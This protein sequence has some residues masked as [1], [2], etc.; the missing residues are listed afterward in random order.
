[1][2]QMKGL[3]SNE[4]IF[5]PRWGVKHTVLHKGHINFVVAIATYNLRSQLVIAIATYN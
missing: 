3:V 2:K 4:I 5:L 1:M